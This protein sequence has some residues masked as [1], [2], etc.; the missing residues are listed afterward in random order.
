M[1]A[2]QW[3]RSIVLIVR[4][5]GI[6]PPFNLLKR[7]VQSQRLLRPV[8]LVV[9]ALREEDSNPHELINSQSCSLLHHLGMLVLILT[10]LDW[11]DRRESDPHGL[12]GHQGH[13]LAQQTNI[14]L[15]HSS[16]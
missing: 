10:L 8:V 16:P 15:C 11:G 5:G 9:L 2:A 7:Q 3:L 6:E 14:C 12:R 4:A 1:S 13:N